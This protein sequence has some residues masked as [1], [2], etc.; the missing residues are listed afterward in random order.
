MR[1]RVSGVGWIRSVYVALGLVGAAST[2][3][4]EQVIFSDPK[5]KA[6]PAAESQ[7][8][9]KRSQG[10][11]NPF[12]NLRPGNSLQG[13][14]A[15]PFAPPS[16][17]APSR[18]PLTPRERDLLMERR[19]WILRAPGSEADSELDVNRAFG[20]REHGVEGNASEST[21]PKGDLLRYYERLESSD[22]PPG[23][24]QPGADPLRN[25]AGPLSLTSTPGRDGY[26]PP[27]E[28]S[29]EPRVSAPA[30]LANPNTG[31]REPGQEANSG[32]RAWVD[33]PF[34]RDRSSGRESSSA[35]SDRSVL[36]SLA[37]LTAPGVAP[38]A[39]PETELT[40][41]ARLLGANP[42]VSPVSE[43]SISSSLDPVTAYPDPTREALN[44]V[45]ASPTRNLSG[46]LLPQ[47]LLAAE[48]LERRPNLAP[49]ATA[50]GP[51]EN[52]FQ[53]MSGAIKGSDST[54]GGK[55]KLHS[56]KAQ[57]ELPG[58]SF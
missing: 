28:R 39:S 29:L 49:S 19:D 54:V 46:P 7:S 56:I 1:D 13:I 2:T 42:I 15:P 22:T 37:P 9:V 23:A 12:S 21:A 36:S 14:T 41:V 57:I 58:R 4:Q 26:R 45:M 17:L 51:L 24:P 20:V 25:S 52:P 50:R 55:R 8:K 53:S 18:S 3:A 33:N 6:S 31:S 47:D 48:S 10:W 5:S 30:F 43:L 34:Q 40:G 11:E 44:P 38:A 32:I 27:G 35:T 16:S